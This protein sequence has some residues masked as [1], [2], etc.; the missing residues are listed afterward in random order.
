MIHSY[1][2]HAANERTFLASLRTGIAV[3]AFGF[4][5][6]KFKLF[7]ATSAAASAVDPGRHL[8]L[9][10]LRGLS[11]AMIGLRLLLSAWRWSSLPLFAFSESAVGAR[12]RRASPRVCQLG[13]AFAAALALIV[14]TACTYLALA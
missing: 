3:T 7:L 11:D 14:A 8:P 2:D 10:G 13:V 12:G 9:D 4:F 6:E 5:I 1:T